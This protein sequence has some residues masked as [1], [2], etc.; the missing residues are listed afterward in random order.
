MP[1]KSIS[2]RQNLD[3]KHAE[4]RAIPRFASFK[5]N[6]LS[7]LQNQG[8]KASEKFRLLS[9]DHG[10]VPDESRSKSHKRKMGRHHRQGSHGHGLKGESDRHIQP[11]F[12]RPNPEPRE[13]AFKSFVVDRVGDP[14]NLKFGALHSYSTA[15]YLRFGT[16]HVVGSLRNQKID[17]AVS[18][19]KGLVLSD[20][21]DLPKTKHSRRRLHQEGA[22]ELKNKPHE[23]HGL[24]IDPEADYVCL[25]AAQQA[26]R[27]HKDAGSYMDWLSSSDENDTQYRSVNTKPKSMREPVDEDLRYNSDTSLSQDITGRRLLAL[28]GSAERKRVQLYGRIDTEPTNLEAWLDLVAYQDHIIGLGQ[29][30]KRTKLT[31]AEKYS[32]AEIKLSIFEKALEKVKDPQGREVLLLGMM[33]EAIKIWETPKL[34]SRWKVIL[35]QNPQNLRLRTKYLDFMQTSFRNFR[36]GE[37]Q[38]AYSDC[39]NMTHWMRS[40]PGISADERNSVFNVQIYVVLRMTLFMRECGFAEHATA[41]WQALLEF[42]FF[43]PMIVLAGE[44]D[45]DIPSGKPTASMRESFERFW[46]SETPRI[47]EDGAKGW[48]SF[49][50]KQGK[51]LQPRA[52]TSNDLN[53][54][55]DH[56][57]SWLASERKHGLLSR[58]PARTID[59]IEENDPYRIILFSDVR[60]FLFDPPSIAG[61]QLILDAFTVFC[62][63]P[64]FAAEGHYS[65]S[66]AWGRDGFLSNDILRLSGVLQDSWKLHF[67]ND[68]EQDSIDIEASQLHVGTGDPFQFPVRDYQVSSDSLFAEKQWFS[69]FHMWQEQCFGGGGPVEVAWVLRSLKSLIGID[70]GED[71]FALYVLALELRISPETV[72]KTAKSISRKRPYS[73]CLYNAYALVEYRLGNIVKG[74]GIITTSINMGKKLYEVPQE[75]TILLWRTWVWETLMTSSAQEAFLRL[76]AIGDEEIQIPFST[77][78]GP[79]NPAVLLRS[80]SVGFSLISN[81]SCSH[82]TGFRC[83]T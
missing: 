5:P 66:R 6:T 47:G 29:D 69:A 22:R 34:L 36:F 78:S 32:N 23:G 56:W 46:E 40:S 70:V 8:V 21:G 28:D 30:L 74:E 52:R 64:S 79:A 1:A 44:Y 61:H 33:Q 26:K 51:P 77:H 72:R 76:L 75:D 42:V 59:D 10:D 3:H 11:D 31:N 35:K 81:K 83:H 48:A 67:P 13:S 58:N 16:G 65:H 55:K 68:Q 17:R 41:T 24:A 18:T 9:E 20:T 15:S 50:Q 14:N 71:A 57:T 45:N 25:E 63:L 38:E 49:S 82:I 62:S 12:I 53:Y 54:S 73:I 2:P 7:Q 80:E 39:L 37:V 60:V 27:R 19:D 43:K 4:Q